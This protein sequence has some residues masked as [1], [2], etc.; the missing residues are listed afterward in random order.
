M[1]TEIRGLDGN[2]GNDDEEDVDP[3]D[4]NPEMY[5]ER[6]RAAAG[7]G[8]GS[9]NDRNRTKHRDASQPP[10]PPASPSASAALVPP[11]YWTFKYL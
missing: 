5:T 11:L 3:L 1:L 8:N 6:N 7:D 10:Q 9:G 2:R 4:Y